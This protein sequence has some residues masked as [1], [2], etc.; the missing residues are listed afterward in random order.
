VDLATG[1][2]TALTSYRDGFA[3]WPTVSPDGAWVAYSY[4][5]V[6]LDQT[7]TME[8]RLHHI[9]TGQ[10]RLLAANGVNA[11]WGP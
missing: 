6:S 9:A 8:L 11:D 3:M 2:V 7:E 5:P 10:E 4:S 1:S